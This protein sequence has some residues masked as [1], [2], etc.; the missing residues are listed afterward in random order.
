MRLGHCSAAR[1]EVVSPMFTK[2]LLPVDLS[3]DHQQVIDIAARIAHQDKGEVTLLH[4]IEL[5]PD[6]TLEE[7]RGFYG[8]LESRARHHLARLGQRFAEYQVPWRL[9]VVY[10]KRAPT[11]L[12][13]ALETSTD[14]IVLTADRI[15]PSNDTGAGAVSYPV[16]LFSQCPVLLLK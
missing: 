7:E 6:V 16:S 14:L 15:A 10:G 3:G 13:Y 12:Q 2:I 8:Q 11:I 9:E 1:E 5:I 4:V